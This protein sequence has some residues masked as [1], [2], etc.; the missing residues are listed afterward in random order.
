MNGLRRPSFEGK[1]FVFTALVFLPRWVFGEKFHEKKDRPDAVVVGGEGN[2]TNRA[3]EISDDTSF[4]LDFAACRIA[5]FFAV[6]DVTLGQNPF[7]ERRLS[8][9]YK[10]VFNSST[11]SKHDAAGVRQ[12][13]VA[14]LMFCR[15]LVKPNTEFL[16]SRRKSKRYYSV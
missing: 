15:A 16:H 2:D 3:D 6:L 11:K 8:W 12:L 1:P 10:Q 14:Q 5:S 13:F 9:T 4:F 7:I